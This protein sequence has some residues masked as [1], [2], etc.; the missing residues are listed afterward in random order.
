[1]GEVQAFE[2]PEFGQ[3]PY[4]DNPI[5]IDGMVLLSNTGV[6][7]LEAGS[8]T[9]IAVVGPNAELVRE[10]EVIS[11]G[12]VDGPEGDELRK[13]ATMLIR[14]A[15]E[16][17]IDGSDFVSATSPARTVS[18][19][20]SLCFDQAAAIASS[21]SLQGQTS[22]ASTAAAAKSSVCGEAKTA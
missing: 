16:E 13:E 14:E 18:G 9:S 17:T 22:A 21:N 5:R 3:T 6:L 15:I 11:R 10:P 20:R 1:M 7:P 4:L 12:W 2:V 19:G 8:L